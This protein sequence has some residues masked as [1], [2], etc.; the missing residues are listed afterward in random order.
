MNR[1]A[2]DFLESYL[3]QVDDRLHAA[4]DA[5]C[6][7]AGRAVALERAMAEILVIAPKVPVDDEASSKRMLG[8]AR[9]VVLADTFISLDR[10]APYRAVFSATM[11]AVV[12]HGRRW[13]REEGPNSGAL[14]R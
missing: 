12:E 7:G 13:I 5:A 9:D 1:L 8:I 2:P 11:I 14:K 3:T 10:S 4:W 6:D